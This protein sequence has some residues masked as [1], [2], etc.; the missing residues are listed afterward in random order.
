MISGF[1]ILVLTYTVNQEIFDGKNF[2]LE[3]ISMVKIFTLKI[4]NVINFC[5]FE[6]NSQISYRRKKF[7]LIFVDA[8]VT[9]IF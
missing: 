1:T 5:R 3:K 8:A 9:K 2:R 6:R 4:F 7:V